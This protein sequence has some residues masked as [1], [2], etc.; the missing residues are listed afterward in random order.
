MPE[1]SF[2][3]QAHVSHAIWPGAGVV[4][5]RVVAREWRD[6]LVYLTDRNDRVSEL[7]PYRIGMFCGC[8][9]RG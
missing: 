4:C 9:R 2:E 6:D 8:R 1:Q 3:I 7:R 5:T